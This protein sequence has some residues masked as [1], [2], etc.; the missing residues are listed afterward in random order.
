[1]FSQS[2]EPSLAVSGSAEVLGRAGCAW[3]WRL[4]LLLPLLARPRRAVH[5]N[6]TLPALGIADVSHSTECP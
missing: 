3:T 5:V 4:F 2:F 6:P 1:M